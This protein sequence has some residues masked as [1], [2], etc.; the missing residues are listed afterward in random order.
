LSEK[1]EHRPVPKKEWAEMMRAL[2]DIS[3]EAYR[4][5]VVKEPRF[6]PYFRSAT[7]ELELS[8]LNV[9]SRP[10][11]RNP[12]GGVESLRAIPWIFAWTQTR[13]NLPAWLGVGEALTAKMKTDGKLLKEMYSKWPWFQTIIDLLEM[14]LVKSEVKIAENYDTQLVTDD[15]SKTL[16]RELRDRLLLTSEAV[17]AVS[18]HIELQENNMVLLR[19]LLVRNPYVDPLNIIQAELLRRLRATESTSEEEKQVLRDALLITINGVANGMR[20]S[21]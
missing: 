19:S 4:G 7:P 13:L 6:V 15:A 9:G 10:A 17:L 1:F 14:I 12:K 3:C 20:N 16:G 2:S 5:V 21:G 11:K 8:G 18:G